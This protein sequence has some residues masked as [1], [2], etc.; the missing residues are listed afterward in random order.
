[1]SNPYRYVEASPSWEQVITALSGQMPGTR[2]CLNKWS[3]PHP[4]TVGLYSVIYPPMGQLATYY[5]LIQPAL[6]FLVIDFGTHYDCQL[7]HRPQPL[8]TVLMQQA[9]DPAPVAAAGALIAG[10]TALGAALGAS[11]GKTEKSV[12][13]GALLGAAFAAL[14]A[15]NAKQG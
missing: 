7:D 9:L 3:L 14:I 8:A 5:K 12:A 11:L 15:A 13:A 10:G 2:L 4:A 1:V 6:G